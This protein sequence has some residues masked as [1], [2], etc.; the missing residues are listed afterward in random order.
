M[1]VNGLA[2][3]ASLLEVWMGARDKE[4]KL[5]AAGAIHLRRKF[6]GFGQAL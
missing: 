6:D 5:L 4:A 2:Y 3:G 1:V